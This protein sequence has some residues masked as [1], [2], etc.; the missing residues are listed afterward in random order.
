MIWLGYHLEGEAKILYAS[1]RKNPETKDSIVPEFLKVCRKFC[2]PFISD[3]KLWTE[4][5]AIR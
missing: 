3:D 2:V 5:Q 4:F 1:Y